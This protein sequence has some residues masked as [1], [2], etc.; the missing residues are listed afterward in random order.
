FCA[1]KGSTAGGRTRAIDSDRRACSGA[2]VADSRPL[3]RMLTV[4]P[5]GT[6]APVKVRLDGELGLIA[7]SLIKVRSLNLA[8]CREAIGEANRTVT[9][10]LPDEKTLQVGML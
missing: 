3:P 2:A 8:Y 1:V 5:A 7:V 9:A 10:Q 4:F 6:E